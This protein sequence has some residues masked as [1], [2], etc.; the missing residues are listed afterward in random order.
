MTTP[1]NGSLADFTE[2]L[3][4]RLD[5]FQ[6]RACEALENGHGV[7]VCAPTGAGKTVVGEF[8]VHLA[9]AAGRKCFYTTPIKALSNQKFNDLVVR[10]GPDRIG[11]LTGDQ[12]INGDA[13]IVV[14]TTEVLRNMLYANSPALHGLS[15]TVMDE[16]HFLAD[17]M[18]G[19]VWEEVILHLP[20][21]V[22]LVSLSATVS[23]AE[24]FGGWIQTVR[25]DTTVVVDEHRPVPLWQHVMVGKRVFDLFDYRATR[26]DR[27]RELLVDPELL[28]HI[29]HRLEADRLA[30][31][32]PRGRG[33]NRGRPTIFRPPMR[34]DVI[35]ILDREGLLPAITFIFS[36]AGCDAAVKQCLRSSLRLTNNEERAR[37]AEVIDRRCADLPEADLIVLDYHEWREGLLRGLAAHHAG[38][39]PVFR[40]TVE[41]LFV[42]GLVKAVF[43]TETL[44]LGINMPARTVVLERLVKYNGEQHVPLTPGEY[45]QL[46]GRAGR[47]GIDVE[48]HAVVLWTP[49]VDPAEVAGLASTRTFPLRSSFAPSYNMTINLVHQMGPVQARKLLESSFA[50]YQADRSVVGLVRGIERGERVLEE[51]AAELGDE[52]AVLDYVRLRAQI[53]ER[54]RAQSRASRLQRRKAAT[55]ALAALRR[56]DIITITHGRRGGLAVVLEADRDSDDP[57]PLVLTEDRW[58]GRIS[59]ADYSGASAPL[60]SMS[61]PKRVEH[62][63]PR[64]R[65]DVA[66]ALRSAA[67]GLDV[68]PTKRRRGGSVERDVDPELASLREQLRRHP[69]HKL[70]DREEKARL[71]ERYLRVER[72]NEQIRKKVAAATNSL[73]RT[74]DRI[75]VL[76]TER[77]FIDAN[78]DDLKVTDDGRLLARIYSESDLLVAESLRSGIWE[79]LDA[80]ELAAVLSSVVYESRGD[81]PSVPGGVDVP[82]GKLRRAL[83]QTRRLWTELRADEQRHRISQ[84]REPDDGFVPAVYRWATTGDLTRSLAASDAAGTGSPLSAGDFVRWCRQV[85]DLLD[86]VRN[87]A[88]SPALRTAAKRAIDDIRRGVVAVDAG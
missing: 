12:S 82:T 43:A 70:P 13:D 3:P 4:F 31:W 32:Q 84:S 58:A 52:S 44:A 18:R 7:L 46:T 42:E 20:D 59:S 87:A 15:Y 54:E 73:A 74:F 38:M 34:P 5:P 35:G 83:N 30:D 71:A 11:L 16:V 41:E 9:L 60:G 66:S 25:G 85:L 10:Y 6:Q 75:V 2:Q 77:G 88:P 27:G 47:R 19:A 81:T 37:I 69:A 63:N 24:E 55:D 1:P 23:N 17:R 53:S 76:L 57:R 56:G 40:H 64:A 28:R 21:D 80:A 8:A 33:R 65:R 29:A 62:R 22:L 49:D 72:D 67:G 86:Q 45:T 61:L 78:A 68:R 14:M 79:G 50:Q 51:I 39:L 26:A 36:R 48:G